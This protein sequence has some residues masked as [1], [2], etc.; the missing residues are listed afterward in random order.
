M[1]QLEIKKF[2]DILHPGGELFEIRWMRGNNVYS[3]YFTDVDKAINEM[4]KY[5][6]ATFYVT[7]NKINSAC[8]G[9]EQRDVILAINDKQKKTT[10]DNDIVEINNILI[11][12]DPKRISGVSSSDEEKQKAEKKMR[13]QFIATSVTTALRI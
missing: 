13:G 3:G 2:L 8:Y 10:G 7:L 11:D 4:G 1:N 9:R 6:R 12:F 5:P